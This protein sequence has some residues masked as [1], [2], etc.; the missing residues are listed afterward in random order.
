MGV[1]RRNWSVSP[2]KN[3]SD[4]NAQKY[5]ANA[6]TSEGQNFL[7][8]VYFNI[9]LSPTFKNKRRKNFPTR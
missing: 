7:L 2:Q 1:A 4:I 8:F 5:S 3:F 9:V 6:F